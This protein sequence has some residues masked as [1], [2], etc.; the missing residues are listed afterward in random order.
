MSQRTKTLTGRS[1][2]SC[3]SITNALVWARNCSDSEFTV[4]TEPAQEETR[5]KTFEGDVDAEVWR[6]EGGEEGGGEEVGVGR[7]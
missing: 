1:S 6:K 3:S 5:N 7:K 2:G 4:N